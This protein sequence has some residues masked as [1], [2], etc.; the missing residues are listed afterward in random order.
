[1]ARQYC[2]ELGKRANCQSL[3][4]LTLARGEVPVPIWMRLF[5]PESWASDAARCQ[6]AGIAEAERVHRPKWE[7]AIGGL[8]EALAAGVRFALIGADAEYGKAPEFRRQLE[9]RDLLYAVGILPQ[10]RVYPA[11]VV[12]HPPVRKRPGVRPPKHPTPSVEA[13]RRPRGSSRSERRPSGR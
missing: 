6:A 5:L 11:G 7:I 1:M 3:V 4:T 2:G 10:Q 8:D 12:M 9:Q 13:C